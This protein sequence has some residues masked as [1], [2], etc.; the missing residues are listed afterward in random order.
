MAI[1]K[2]F[3]YHK[4]SEDG[5]NKMVTLRSAYT[6]LEGV[7]TRLI[8]Q[9]RELSEALTCLETSAM[10]ANKGVNVTDPYAEAQTED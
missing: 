6:E 7:L 8:P 10:Y 9:S 5:L 3:A 4:P 2:R 1:S